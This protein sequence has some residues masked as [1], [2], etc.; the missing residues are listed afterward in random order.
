[1]ANFLNHLGANIRG[2]GTNM[3]K[4]EGVERLG[5]KKVRHTIIPDRIEAGSYMLAAA[6]SDGNVLIKN[7]IADHIKPDYRQIAEAGAQGRGRGRQYPRDRACGAQGGRYQNF[8]LSGISDGYA[9]TVYEFN[10]GS[11]RKLSDH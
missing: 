7:V 6:I 11:G 5:E 8:A 1:M 3:I 10:G 9:V 4:I 2:A